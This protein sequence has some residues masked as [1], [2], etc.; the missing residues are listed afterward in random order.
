[1]KAKIALILTLLTMSLSGPALVPSAAVYADCND[2]ASKQEV[3][4]A[5]G[6][7]KGNPC[8]DNGVNNIVSTIVSVLSYVVGVAAIIMLIVAGFKY[9]ASGG[10]SGKISSA[11]NTLIYAVIG[12]VVAVL[13]QTIVRFVITN[14]NSATNRCSAGHHRRASDNNCVPDN[15]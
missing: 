15:P 1:M 5:L 4:D 3:V 14:A 9:I 8:N 7:V 6:Q 12:I 10:D 11:K 13:A 2:T